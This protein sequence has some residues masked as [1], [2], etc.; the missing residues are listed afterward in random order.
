MPESSQSYSEQH[1]VEE[2]S[3]P[4]LHFSDAEHHASEDIQRTLHEILQKLGK[5]N[6]IENSVN[7]LQAT[8]L[9]LEK[10]TKTLEGFELKARKDISDLQK[11]L[12]LTEEKYKT[13]LANVDKKQEH[14]PQDR[15][16]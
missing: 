10:R 3:E 7:N 2:D 1:H 6:I 12:S 5:L 14:Q 15:N 13:N 9:N 16:H 8:L 11:S 4:P